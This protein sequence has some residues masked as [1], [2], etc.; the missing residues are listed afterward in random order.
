MTLVAKLLRSKLIA[1]TDLRYVYLPWFIN[2]RTSHTALGL[3]KRYNENTN[4][5]RG[6]LS[7]EAKGMRGKM[8]FLPNPLS[9]PS[10]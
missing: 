10:L 9:P 1:I 7:S 8:Y 4:F 6:Y 3:Y 5:I 2:R